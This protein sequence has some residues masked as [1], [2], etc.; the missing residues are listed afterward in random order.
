MYMEELI[1]SHSWTTFS[2]FPAWER[3]TKH[4]SRDVLRYALLV[5]WFFVSFENEQQT[6][7][8]KS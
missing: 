3:F 6:W 4:Y 7:A 1:G 2:V 5:E 8:G